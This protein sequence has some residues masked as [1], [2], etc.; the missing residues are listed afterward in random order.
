MELQQQAK[1]LE[2]KL[3]ELNSRQA[4]FARNRALN[5]SSKRLSTLVSR[6]TAKKERLKSSLIKR[7]IR[8]IQ[9][10]KQGAAVVIIG[11]TAIPA[12][13]IGEAR[14]QIKR[15]NKQYL[16][17]S[18]QRDKR[19][20]YAKR[21]HSGNTAIRVGRHVFANAF[22]QR[23]DSGRWHILQR[24]TSKR[25]PIDLAKIPISGSITEAADKH[26]KYIV[27]EYFPS[28]LVKDLKYRIDKLSKWK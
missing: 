25:Y 7:K 24:K 5:R 16:V 19:G 10:K 23:L 6:D 18:A 8:V 13:H 11:R 9:R 26:S 15:K 2:R 28:L 14:T 27:S 22:L 12:I 3:N 21:Q 20:R 4:L 1:Q 17:S